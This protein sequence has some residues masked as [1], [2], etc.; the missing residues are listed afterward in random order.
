M[1][2]APKEDQGELRPLLLCAI[3][4]PWSSGLA[5]VERLSNK[6]ERITAACARAATA[7]SSYRLA[8][9]LDRCD[10]WASRVSITARSSNV[11]KATHSARSVASYWPAT[12]ISVKRNG[13]RDIDNAEILLLLFREVG[14]HIRGSLSSQ[15]SRQSREPPSPT[16]LLINWLQVPDRR[17]SVELSE[18]RSSKLA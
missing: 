10:L 8:T 7:L 15:D 2:G 14:L 11:R 12:R 17:G 3:F 6:R 5:F 13:P 16:Q 18:Y 9:L 1:R 4:V